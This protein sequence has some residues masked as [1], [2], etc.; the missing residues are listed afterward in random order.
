M[1]TDYSKMVFRCYRCGVKC[2]SGQYWITDDDC[3]LC[4]Y[5][6]RDYTT[7]CEQCGAIYYDAPDDPSEELYVSINGEIVCKSCFRKQIE[8]MA[9]KEV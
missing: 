7:R 5:C 9:L 3:V 2:E 8:R 1:S 6:F 4:D